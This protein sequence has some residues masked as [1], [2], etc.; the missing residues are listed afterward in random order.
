VRK[1]LGRLVG[2]V[3]V[4]AL[5]LPIWVFETTGVPECH[6]IGKVLQFLLELPAARP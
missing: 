6:F 3:A 2:L 5:F 1:V 4:D